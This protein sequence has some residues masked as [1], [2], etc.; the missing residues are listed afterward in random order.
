MRQ[1]TLKFY[2]NWIIRKNTVI[3]NKDKLPE[4]ERSI[5]LKHI[6]SKIKENLPANYTEAFDHPDTRFK[7]K[8]R[9]GI[10]KEI[11]N[12][13]SRGVWKDIQRKDLP[14]GHRCIKCR[15]VFEV[16]RNGIFRPRLVACGYSQIPGVDFTDSYAPVINDV[17]WRIL[18]I[19]KLVWNLSAKI[20][21]VETA[22]L[23]GDLD[24]EIYMESPEGYN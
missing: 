21:D 8:W 19:A 11:G 17:T 18:I 23:H 12:M 1:T 7:K 4:S 20:I 2:T 16:K 24:E 13:V 10:A 6:V 5:W 14:S 22:F 3:K 15:W 9:D